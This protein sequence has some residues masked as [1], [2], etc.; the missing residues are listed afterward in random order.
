MPAEGGGGGAGLSSQDLG[1]FGMLYIVLSCLLVIITGVTVSNLFKQDLWSEYSEIHIVWA[2]NLL[3]HFFFDT[4][5][6]NKVA[7]NDIRCDLAL[8]FPF[9]GF[10][11]L[12]GVL[13]INPLHAVLWERLH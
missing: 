7:E 13:L 4:F 1:Y 11:N 5:Y 10:A 3:Q 12:L 8:L 2:K 9:S 6:I